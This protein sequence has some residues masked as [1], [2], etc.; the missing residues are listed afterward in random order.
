MIRSSQSTG[1]PEM[2]TNAVVTAKSSEV[3]VD[4]SHVTEIAQRMA[5]S[6]TSE[7]C[8]VGDCRDPDYWN[9]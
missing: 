3:S 1:K 9:K 4:L 2:D 8:N 6:G 5:N 7:E